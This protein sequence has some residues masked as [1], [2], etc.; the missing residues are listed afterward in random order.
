MSAGYQLTPFEVGQVKAHAHH[1]LGP[2]AIARILLKPD[3]KSHWSDRAIA[4]T[5]EALEADPSWRGERQEG[6][7]RPRA[8]TAKEDKLVVQEVFKHRGS[9]KVT[10]THLK[11]KFRHLRNLCD[12][13]VENRLH[14]ANL[15]W[16]RRRRKTLVPEKYL[17]PRKEYAK[18]VLKKHHSTLRR[19]AYT[20]GTVWYLDR[21]DEELEDTKRRALG[22]HVWRMAD[23]SDALFQDTIGPSSYGK[24]QGKPV[25][26]WGMLSEGS[27]KIRI[28]PDKEHMNRWWYSW[29][30][31]HCFPNW[32]G[33]CTHIVQ[34]FETCLRCEE[35]LAA[36]RKIGVELVE[37]Y[38]KCSQ[39]LN[40]I[41]NAWKL[42]KDRLY[43]TLPT[44]LETREDFVCRLKNAVAWLNRNK[45][46]DLLYLSHNQKERAKELL[47]NKGGRTS[48]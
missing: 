34:D 25:K 17:E 12:G 4:D 24:A 31:E 27:L 41:E 22:S 32:L 21:T 36:M 48:W 26:V 38:P 3:G 14:D 2:T 18:A 6:S 16:L 43:D 19:W 1:G 23:G 44:Q 42:L 37:D 33:E 20:D 45:H 9:I 30:V 46:D 29:I 40:A 5:L 39:D 13:T 10:V 11:K 28:L 8:T 7:G 47:L 35:P 15:A